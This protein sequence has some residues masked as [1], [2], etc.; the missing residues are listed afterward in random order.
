[1]IGTTSQ[2]YG[3]V[4]QYF[5][6]SSIINLNQWYFIS[7][8]LSGT[9]GY[10]YVNGSQVRTGTLNVPNNI[11]RTANYIGK[12]NNPSDSNADAVFDEFKIYQRALSSV[13]IMNEYKINS[14]NGK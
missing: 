14:N 8:V 2:I 5:Q 1:M 9:T 12:S 6:T 13:E 4:S 7:F 10:I 11:I 3:R